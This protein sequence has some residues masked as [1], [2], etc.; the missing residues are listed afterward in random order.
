MLSCH[1][2]AI[3]WNL[4]LSKVVIFS[5]F[6][7]RQTLAA[8]KPQYNPRL[9]FVRKQTNGLWNSV[10]NIFAR[11]Y[12]LERALAD[13]YNKLIE[14]EELN[15]LLMQP[16]KLLF[17]SFNAAFTKPILILIPKRLKIQ[18]TRIV[19]ARMLHQLF[20]LNLNRCCACI[21]TI[22]NSLLSSLKEPLL[23]PY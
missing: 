1:L 5:G 3:V 12:T 13:R 8:Q 21:I 22:N 15:S 11:F 9:C 19:V 17:T 4:L 10:G 14:T 20:L 6:P 23:T 18:V 7:Q 16:N 2:K